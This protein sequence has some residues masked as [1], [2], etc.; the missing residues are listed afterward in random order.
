MCIAVNAYT[1]ERGKT[2][3]KVKGQKDLTK[4]AQKAKAVKEKAEKAKADR[5]AQAAKRVIKNLNALGHRVGTVSDEIDKLLIKGTTV[6][7]AEKK[8]A[9][10]FPDAKNLNPWIK[11]QIKQA[12]KKGFEIK[13]EEGG[14]VKVVVPEPPPAAAEQNENNATN[15]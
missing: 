13:E 3:Q 12:K 15:G 8:I 4:A 10:K 7:A 2:M 11:G 6:A 5:I 14:I 9:K 1:K